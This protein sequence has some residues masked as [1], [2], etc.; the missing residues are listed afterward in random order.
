[1]VIVGVLDDM[2]E[3]SSRARF[4]AQ[5]TAALLMVSWGGVVLVDLGALHLDDSMF[6]LHGMDVPLT[7]FCAVGV[8]NALNMCDGIDGLAGGLSLVPL[9][10]LAWIAQGAEREMLLLLCIVVVAFLLFNLRLPG[11]RRALVFM[12]DAGGMFLGFA[13]TWFFI[14]MSQGEGR[15]M[16]PLTALWLLLIPLFDTVWLIFRRAG[17]GR[18][19]TNPDCEHLHHVLQM[20]GLG[21]QPH[22]CGHLDGS[23][24]CRRYRHRCVATR[25]TRKPDVL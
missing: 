25:R 17:T 22:R 3:L 24:R 1:M 11:R 8:I 7:V 18:W 16:T 6:E 21:G 19:P 14:A 15:L 4:V 9:A 12:G 23:H 10:G 20:T 13:I 5:I 2:H